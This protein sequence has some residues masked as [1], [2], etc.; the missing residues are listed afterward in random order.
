M[1]LKLYRFGDEDLSGAVAILNDVTQSVAVARQREETMRQVELLAETSARLG[2]SVDLDEVF[3]QLADIVVPVLADWVVLDV[4]QPDGMVH[5]IGVRHVDPSLEDVAL[6]L[7]AIQP[8]PENRRHPAVRALVKEKPVLLTDVDEETLDL[9]EPGHRDLV[10]RLGARSVLSV[11]LFARGRLLGSMT[12]VSSAN[13]KRFGATQLALARDIA[14]RGALAIDNARLLAEHIYL[15]RRLQESLL[16]P[17]LPHIPGIELGARYQSAGDI[18]VGGDF[19]D[20]FRTGTRSWSVVVGDVS[21]KG[22]D[23]AVT[24]TLARY[25]IRAAAMQARA[26]RR[27]L[28]MLNDALFDQ[29]D[30]ERFATA[31][32]VRVRTDAGPGPKK[33]TIACGGHPLPL[34]LRADGSIEEAGT[35]G[36]VLGLMERVDIKDT[37]ALLQP[38]DALVM[39]TDGV[40]EARSGDHMLGIHGLRTT[41]AGCRGLEA[42]AIAERVAKTALDFQ[43]DQQRDDMAIVVIRVPAE[44]TTT[45]S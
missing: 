20:F 39:F 44:E 38:G 7:A 1:E 3:G 14:A 30:I 11:P 37:N 41:L 18:D 35:S 32:F 27:I 31:V 21:G 5:R 24:T 42:D 19:Y 10:E 6:A 43:K 15:A 36:T 22:P 16:P 8:D 45:G 29:T 17:S 28:G 12:L 34:V 25:T 40:T 2:S 4:V 9:F 23:A 13:P 26:P 33:L